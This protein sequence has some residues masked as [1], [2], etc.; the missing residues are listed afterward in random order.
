MQLFTKESIDGQVNLTHDYLFIEK[1]NDPEL[2][3][4]RNELNRLVRTGISEEKAKRMISCVFAFCKIARYFESD[5]NRNYPG[6]I[7]GI[8]GLPA[9]DVE[10]ILYGMIKI[11]KRKR[12]ILN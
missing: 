7:K 9:T 3:W 5:D 12:I 11:E 4:M 1:V 10:E 2:T 8:K 6:L